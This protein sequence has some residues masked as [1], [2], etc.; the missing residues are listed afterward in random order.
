MSLPA[1]V[2]DLQPFATILSGELDS[3]FNNLVNLLNGTDQT[4]SIRVRSNDNAFAVA[5]FDQLGASANI[6]ELFSS[7]VE[8]GRIEKDGDLVCL[9]LT[10]VNGVYTFSSIPVGPNADP[11]TDNQLARKKYT[12]DRLVP[13]S[14]NWLVED[15]STYPLTSD[16]SG[17]V[18]VRVP[19][20]VGG[21]L[22]KI[23]II[24][25]AGT[26]TSGGSV[27]FKARI[28]NG[29]T[30]GNGVSF[31]NTNSAINTPYSEDFSDVSISEG[32][33]IFFHITA[34]SGTVSERN[35]HVT[36]EGYRK[37]S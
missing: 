24:R 34:R 18:I 6:L 7:G 22:S 25:T 35:V 17:L 14:I 9:G 28:F 19:P 31:D 12:D 21:F 30:L 16:D 2:T 15:P 10:G 33:Y 4:R 13:F 20:V 36:V 27:T 23:T 3:E 8:V 26:H 1:R 11:A 37:V 5:R 32:N 29:S